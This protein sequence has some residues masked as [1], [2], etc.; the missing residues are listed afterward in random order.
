M[1]QEETFER[2]HMDSDGCWVRPTLRT[3]VKEPSKGFLVGTSAPTWKK[4][5]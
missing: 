4:P 3:L 2:D 5:A 1:M